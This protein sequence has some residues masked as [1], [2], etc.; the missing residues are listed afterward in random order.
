MTKHGPSHSFALDELAL[1]QR[2]MNVALCHSDDETELINRAPCSV[3]ARSNQAPAAGGSRMPPCGTSQ[4]MAP[5]SRASRKYLAVL[6]H[7]LPRILELVRS[8]SCTSSASR[9]QPD[10]V[11]LYPIAAGGTLKRPAPTP[12]TK[13]LLA[14]SHLDDKAGLFFFRAR[15]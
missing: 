9:Q 4:V 12:R 8:V 15:A 7:D 1:A 13:L 3:A 6:S 11:S 2:P 5:T 14:G 10:F